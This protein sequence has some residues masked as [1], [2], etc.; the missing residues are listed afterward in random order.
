MINTVRG[1]VRPQKL[2]SLLDLATPISSSISRTFAQ[3]S[4]GS[5]DP[6]PSAKETTEPTQ[7]TASGNVD[8]N[9]DNPNKENHNANTEQQ[10]TDNINSNSTT[11]KLLNQHVQQL[12]QLRGSTKVMKQTLTDNFAP[13][14]QWIYRKVGSMLQNWIAGFIKTRI[15]TEFN[16]EDTVEGSLDA[17]WTFHQ[18]V[19]KEDYTTLSTMAAAKVVDAVQQTGQE[20]RAN[21]LIWRNEVDPD[22]LEAELRGVSFWSKDQ[23]EAYD[24][25]QAALAKTNDGRAAEM[26]KAPA[27]MWLVLSIQFRAKQQVTITREEDGIVVA[28]LTDMRA[29]R[30]KFARGPLPEGTYPVR[31]LDSPWWLLSL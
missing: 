4:N 6:N 12:Q 7:K 29:T 3:S 1:L 2:T 22:S 28:E 5:R 9:S 10:T 31:T 13:W 30:W 21:G 16:V 14:E 20:Y 15:E 25:K 23:I 8:N 26:F 19:A 17:F 18:L 24:S 27:N 11:Q